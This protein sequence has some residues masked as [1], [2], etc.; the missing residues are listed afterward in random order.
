[1]QQSYE[2]GNEILGIYI[3]KIKNKEGE[4]SKKGSNLLGEIRKDSNGNSVYFL[5]YPC[6]DWFDND[7]YNNLSTWIETVAK[8]AERRKISWQY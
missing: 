4:I 2:K 6:Y 1:L 8:K 3:H 7:G 5:K